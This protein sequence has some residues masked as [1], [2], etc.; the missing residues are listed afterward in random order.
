ML[1]NLRKN[2]YHCLSRTLLLAILFTVASFGK[3]QTFGLHTNAIGDLTGTLNIGA[4]YAVAP[5]QSVHL[6]IAGNPFSFGENT[7][8]KSFAVRPEWRLWLYEP[9]FGWYAGVHFL[10]GTYDVMGIGPFTTLKNNRYDGSFVGAGL[11]VGYSLP[12]SDFWNID[13]GASFGGGKFS[14]D[15]TPLDGDITY[16]GSN[17]YFG[18]T[19]VYVSFVYFLW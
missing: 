14:F 6:N 7:Q 8:M 3:A 2:R 1:K 9:H 18:P 10:Y 12:I 16:T 13:F 17:S 11:S 5:H 4:E 15:K 19:Q